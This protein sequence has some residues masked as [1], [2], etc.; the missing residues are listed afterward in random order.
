MTSARQIRANRAN[1]RASTGPRSAKGKAHASQNARRHGL[2]L[3]TSLEPALSTEAENLAREI[4]GEQTVVP[5]ILECARRI[6]VAQIDLQRVRAARLDLL[7]R[8]LSNPNYIPPSKLMERIRVLNRLVGMMKRK[9]GA[10][11]QG[12]FFSEICARKQKK[13]ATPG[14]RN[15]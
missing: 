9:T 8:H 4:A 15:T 14:N 1:A 6:A 7:K 2:S 11:N 10:T 12:P 5:E 13:A 3:S